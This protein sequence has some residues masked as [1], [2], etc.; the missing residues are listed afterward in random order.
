M[1]HIPSKNKHGTRLL[2]VAASSVLLFTACTSSAATS[3]PASSAPAASAAPAGSAA[4]ASAAPASA[5]PAASGGATS[6]SIVFGVLHPFTGNYASVGAASYAGAKAAAACIN[7]AGGVLGKKL[8]IDTADTV[9]DPADA[10]PAT[11]KLLAVDGAVGIIGPG[12]LEIGAV[13]PIL[14]SHKIP[15]MFEGGLTAMDN[16]TDP[17]LWRDGP[18]DG[19]EGVA[20]AVYAQSKG[21]KTA[22]FVFS[23]I[24]TA[25]DFKKPV[26]AAWTAIGGKIVANVNLTPGQ[27]SY[28]SEVLKVVQAKPDVIFTQME[29]STAGAAFKDFQELDNLSIPFIASD[30]SIGKD[31]ISAV[32]AQ[33]AVK[34]L[35]GVEGSSAPGPGG[36]AFN[37]CYQEG[38]G[39]GQPLASAPYSYDGTNVL[40]LAMDLA[41]T[42]NSAQVVQALSKVSNPGSGIQTYTDYA[43][44]YAAIKG[45]ATAV[46]YDGAGTSMDFNKYH[47]V[48]GPFQVVKWD[49]STST[50]KTIFTVSASKIQAAAG[51]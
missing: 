31:W 39:N 12:G 34:A 50:F 44:A 10:V 11:N 26:Q 17:Y 43:S 2:A 21:Y 18:S 45:G 33:N 38:N 20:M 49:P 42:T 51:G 29:P 1:S 23:T 47:N 27:S 46:N 24:Q 6:G 9:G 41:G 22:A 40:A 16:N 3:A 28:R 8:V 7:A 35:V 15:F 48:F 32:G 30:T 25:Q 14:D 13:Q 19:S 36:A 37:K 5:A 4:P